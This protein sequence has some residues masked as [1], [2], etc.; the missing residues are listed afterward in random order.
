[1]QIRKLK[2]IKVDKEII[3]KRQIEAKLEE[4]QKGD[5]LIVWK[6]D[7]MGRSLHHLIVCL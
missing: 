3:R 5:T 6:L 7:R 2:G 1:M 4:I